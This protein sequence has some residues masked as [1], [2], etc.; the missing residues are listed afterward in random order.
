MESPQYN[1][2]LQ[3]R[4]NINLANQEKSQI[5]LRVSSIGFKVLNV[6]VNRQKYKNFQR[7]KN[8]DGLKL[9]IPS[10]LLFYV[11]IILRRMTLF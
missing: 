2:F 1:L 9:S 8:K 6:D 4:D 11:K 7:A 5:I 10:I 3:A